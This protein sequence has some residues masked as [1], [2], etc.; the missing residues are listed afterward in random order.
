[1]RGNTGLSILLLLVSRSLGAP[2]LLSA[3]ADYA[4]KETHNPPAAW[5]RLDDEVP[6][7]QILEMR[8]GL[9]QS[10]FA[11]LEEH[12]SKSSDP[13]HAQYGNHLSMKEVQALVAP[14]SDT[15]DAVSSWFADYGVAA[16]RLVY[17]AA[18]D[19]VTVRLPLSQVEEMLNTKYHVF[20]HSE[21]GDRLIRAPTW[22]LPK[23]LH[24]HID[25][26]Q[27]TNSFFRLK[28]QGSL[29]RPVDSVTLSSALQLDFVRPGGGSVA[30]VC[31]ETFVT[32]T[33][34]R[35][36]YGTI[37]YTVQAVNKN[38]MGLNNF[39]GEVNNRSDTSLFLTQFRPEAAAAAYSFKTQVINGGN[40]NQGHENATRLRAGA[41]VEG[42][43]D[44]ETMLGI[45]WPTNLTTF[46]TGGQPP[47]TPDATETTN[48]NEPYLDWLNALTDQEDLPYVISSSYADDEQTVP[49]SY[50]Q[51][52]CQGFAQLGARGISLFFGSGDSGVG[53]QGTCVSNNGSS[54]S[55]FLAMFPASCPYVTTVGG[56]RNF[57]PE[58]V[59]SDTN[60]YVSGGGFSR[61]FSRPSYQD[62][63]V[64]AY[65]KT[66]KSSF[67]G[68][69]NPD[70]RGYP[71]VAAQGYRYAVVWNGAVQ[72]VDG[73]SAATP[74]F[75][76]IVAL[77]NDALLAAGKPTLGFLNPFLYS[78]GL[79]G[80]R[81]ITKGSATGCGT[82]G[83]PATQGWDAV[84]GFGTPD[85]QKLV[86]LAL[87]QSTSS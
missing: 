55:T 17:S 38:G 23:S 14:D 54:S 59:A 1:M 76:A 4:V 82:T 45:A 25:V 40:N 83:F 18:G 48:G 22:S 70:G 31:N 28:K 42:D 62:N 15:V 8:F 69:Y 36:F 26:V 32:P 77:I 16:E 47:F 86:A 49:Q 37:N 75:A 52:V 21:D 57:N 41:D 44:S 60:G 72:T 61:Y 64:P 19:W 50:A 68:L 66:L 12:L 74:A 63:V 7:D 71:D 5:R 81:D 79:N 67:K 27:P 78:T 73:T 35:T 80:L 87:N 53:A 65:V 39:L 9:R 20:E 58:I 33:C 51:K 30:S 3:R 24:E 10:N 85:F 43:L 13:Y 11:K 84:T 29:V 6:H 46:N 56:T 34:L 2:S